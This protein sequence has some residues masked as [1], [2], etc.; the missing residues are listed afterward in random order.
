[1]SKALKKKKMVKVNSL[2]LEAL[3]VAMHKVAKQTNSKYYEHLLSRKE[4]IEKNE[5]K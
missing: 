5:S 1:M 2:N 3:N 4:N